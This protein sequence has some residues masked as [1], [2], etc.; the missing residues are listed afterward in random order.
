MFQQEKLDLA[1]PALECLIAHSIDHKVVIT[2]L[3]C[4]L[5]LHV[6]QMDGKQR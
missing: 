3:R 5:R 2:A 4:L 1:I 6:T